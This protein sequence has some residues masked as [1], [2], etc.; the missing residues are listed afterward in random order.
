MKKLNY[1]ILSVI[2]SVSLLLS[3]C[4]SSSNNS[5]GNS[6]NGNVASQSK[7]VLLDSACDLDNISI[8]VKGVGSFSDVKLNLVDADNKMIATLDPRVSSANSMNL[9]MAKHLQNFDKSLN[10]KLCI[11]EQCFTDKCVKSSCL[12]YY[13]DPKICNIH[14]DC[15]YAGDSCK[16]FSCGDYSTN[17]TC[18]SQ[19]R[20]MWIKADVK[21]GT[22][23]CKSKPCY[24]FKTES[25]CM[26]SPQCDW[27]GNCN[28]FACSKLATNIACDTDYRCKWTESEFTHGLC[29]SIV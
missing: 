29:E 5:Q 7:L 16:R 9:I 14:A 18:D 1:V 20:C 22:D 6:Q 19:T 21:S 23:Y 26:A 17:V 25:D 15:Q 12:K 8:L 13:S 24:E 10:Y 28:S 27:N 11:G 2:L 4:A 3:G